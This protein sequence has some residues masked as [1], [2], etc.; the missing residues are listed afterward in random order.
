VVSADSVVVAAEV[1]LEV[2]AEVDSEAAVPAEAGKP[3]FVMRALI[4]Q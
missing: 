4:I 2:L 3:I 1:D